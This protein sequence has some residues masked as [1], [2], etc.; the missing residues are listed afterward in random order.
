MKL[1]SKTR[2]ALIFWMT[3]WAFAPMGCT[4]IRDQT[5]VNNPRQRSVF[6]EHK[7]QCLPQV[8]YSYLIGHLSSGGEAEADQAKEVLISHSK[9][10]SECRA[11]VIGVIMHSMDKP[12]LDFDGDANSYYL[13]RYGSELLG[14][15]KASE[16][17][18]LL[19][20]HL[21]SHTKTFSSS[22]SH[23]PALRGVIEMGP[24]AL[25]KLDTTLK[26]NPDPKM[27]H[28]A[29]YCIATIGGPSAIKSLQEALPSET[30]KCVSRFIRISLNSLDGSGKLKDRG[31]WFSGVSCNE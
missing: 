25:P 13:W 15:L 7:I 28:A 9:R 19:I 22:M 16:A 26:G 1:L 5:D 29:V 23:M 17:L 31:E 10:S 4:N 3:Y 18:D 24:M 2:G 21:D 14:E 20:S 8:D 30:D 27:R 11:E 6:V 12:D